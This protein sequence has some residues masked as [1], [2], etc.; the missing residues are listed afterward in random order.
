ME[1]NSRL[2]RIIDLY[3]DKGLENNDMHD[4]MVKAFANASQEEK[5]E[6]SEYLNW[7]LQEVNRKEKSERKSKKYPKLHLPRTSKTTT[8]IHTTSYTV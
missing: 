7:K 8:Y 2:K 1:E 5:Q 4:K 6:G 3:V